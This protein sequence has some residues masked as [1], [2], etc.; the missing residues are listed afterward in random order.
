MSLSEIAK[1]I[2]VMWNEISEEKKNIY[3]KRAADDKARFE[4]EIEVE[5]KSNGGKKLLTIGEK[6]AKVKLLGIRQPSDGEKKPEKDPN[7][8]KKPL[9]AFFIYLKKR[10]MELAN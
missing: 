9:T 1:I 6:K 2:G 5:T 4:R 8:S 7:T 10:R 3:K